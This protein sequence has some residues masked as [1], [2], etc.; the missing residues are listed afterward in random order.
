MMDTE[1]VSNKSLISDKGMELW[2]AL[3]G[4]AT[5]TTSKILEMTEEGM[6]IM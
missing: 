4:R 6:N 5:S 3:S 1:E 2:F